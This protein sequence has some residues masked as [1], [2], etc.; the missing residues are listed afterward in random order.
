MDGGYAEYATGDFAV[1]CTIGVSGCYAV[2][3]GHRPAEHTDG[4]NWLAVDGHVKWLR[5][6]SVSAGAAAYPS[7]NPNQVAGVWGNPAGT[8]NMT[9]TLGHTYTLTFSEW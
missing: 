9:D 8:D 3:S 6:T 5:A 2:A 7:G 1:P 4:A